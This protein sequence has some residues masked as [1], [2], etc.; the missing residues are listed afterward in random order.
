MN[1][2]NGYAAILKL[3]LAFVIG[4]G[5]AVAATFTTFERVADHDADLG[6]V[7]RQLDRIEAKVDRLLLERRSGAT[8]LP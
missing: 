7:E 1:Q 8:A 3:V 4:A 2:G 5:G 6:R